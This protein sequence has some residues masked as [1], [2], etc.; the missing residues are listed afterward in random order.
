MSLLSFKISINKRKILTI[1]FFL[2][3]KLSQK[4]LYLGDIILIFLLILFLNF[5]DI[6]ITEISSIFFEKYSDIIKKFFSTPPPLIEGIK[7][8]NLFCGIILY[9]VNY[10][11]L[12][13]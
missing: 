12:N 3:P 8:I 13:L 11:N 6:V 9:I 7:I 4:K 10:I 2:L 5:L 1:N